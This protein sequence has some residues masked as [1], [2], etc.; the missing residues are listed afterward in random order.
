MKIVLALTLSLSFVNFL[1]ANNDNM[2]ASYQLSESKISEIQSRVDKMNENELVERKQFLEKEKNRLENLQDSSQNPKTNKELAEDIE[3]VDAE[4]GYI[5]QRIIILGGLVALS[6]TT[7]DADSS[8]YTKPVITILGAN[9]A[10]V[11]LGTSYIDAGA[12]SDGGEAVMFDASVVDTSTVGHIQLHIQLL[13]H[14]VIPE[15]QQEQ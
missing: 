9:P 7:D 6:N 3:E 10:T 2:L 12:T 1:H 4:I 13:I 5:A 11:E 15:L 8:D 14:R